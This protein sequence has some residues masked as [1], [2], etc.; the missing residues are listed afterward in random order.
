MIRI[1]LLL[2]GST[3]CAQSL[4]AQA[5]VVT[6]EPP[7]DSARITLRDELLHFRDTLNSI[8][9]AAA[10]LQRD[11]RQASAASLISRARVMRDACTRSERNVP[12]A[13]KAVVAADA[14]DERRMRR[15]TEMLRALDQLRTVL[16]S[17]RSDF[18][19]MSQP[20]KGEQVR[21]Y[22][23]ARAVRVLAAIR[24][25]EQSLGSFFSAMGIKVSPLGAGNRALAG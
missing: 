10:R 7:L 15:R 8:D 3:L 9:A 6:P 24:K 2:L 5:T 22:A 25:Y 14:S 21:G 20:G 18:D 11:F 1:Y 4:A 23:N 17:C 19:A 12:S 13:R 16:T